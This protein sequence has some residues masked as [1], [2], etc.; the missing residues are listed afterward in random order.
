MVTTPL[1]QFFE[2]NGL[3]LVNNQN[4]RG[5][6]PWN[7]ASQDSSGQGNIYRNEHVI[8][9]RAPE[10]G[11]GLLCDRCLKVLGIDERSR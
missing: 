6:T 9:N 5:G 3:M 11:E 7:R 1:P 2:A 8:S 10:L 4:E